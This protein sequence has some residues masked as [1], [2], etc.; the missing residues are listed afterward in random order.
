MSTE[1]QQFEQVKSEVTLAYIDCN[2]N[3]KILSEHAKEIRN[4]DFRASACVSPEEAF[5]ILTDAGVDSYNGFD[6]DVLKKLPKESRIR[7]AREG[8]VCLYVEGDGLPSKE[9]LVADEY[10]EWEPG[11]TRIWWD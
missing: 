1:S 7:I 8:S 4:L 2:I 5:N 6:V 11:V 3:I 9:E 10:D